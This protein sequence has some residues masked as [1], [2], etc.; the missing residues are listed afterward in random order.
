MKQLALIGKPNSGKSSLFNKLTGLNQKIGNYSGVT[1][2][3]KS[4][5]FNGTKI[6]DLPGLKSLWVDSLDEKISLQEILKYAEE[7]SPLL[8]VANGL[9]LADSLLLFS[10]IAD[11]QLPI[12]LVINFKDELKKSQLVLD[13]EKIKNH[14]GCEV[15]LMNSKTGEGLD[16]L[17][18][19]IRENKAKVPHTFRRSQFEKIDENGFQNIYLKSIID[20]Q[21]E[22]TNEQYNLLETD[23]SQRQV[24]V[25]KITNDVLKEDPTKVDILVGSKRAD[26]ILLHPIWGMLI[27]IAVMLVVF[28]SVF[29]LS[30]IPMDWIDQFFAWASE[31]SAKISIPWLSS[32]MSEGII[33][34]L[35]GVLIFIP[36]IAILFLLLGILENSGYLS[37]ISYI[38][39]NFLQKFGLS[40]KSVVPLMSSWACSIPAIMSTRMIED[41]RERMAVIMASPLMTCSARLPVYTILI[42]VMY[43]KENAGWIDAKGITLFA[44]YLL[45]VIATL[46]VAYIINK[47][48]NITSQS[49]W[50][51]ELPMYRMPNWK[52]VFYNAYSKTKSFVVSAGKIIFLISIV[53]WLLAS[54]S[55][56]T[57]SFIDQK[58]AEYQAT[59]QDHA[60]EVNRESIALEYSYAGYLGKVIEPVIKPL[61]Y[62][63]KIGIALITS[64]AAREVFVGTLSTIYSIGSEDESSIVERLRNETNLDTGE[65]RYN[66]ATSISLLLF[67]VFAM[68]CMSTLAIVRKE[69]GKWKYAAYQFA[70]MFV[71]AYGFAFL[72]YQLL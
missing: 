19:L 13:E 48:S 61:G 38:A 6:I 58:Y 70:F 66:M 2:E 7:G 9:Q 42:A 64:F 11:L 1:V 27:F 50:T 5:D 72:A 54:F 24:L 59:H 47:R 37:R 26:K 16:E 43:P 10:E 20:H 60:S 14:L 44:L 32:L 45:G 34:G 68:Q 23:F 46:V 22:F 55:P 29:T 49:A 4:G 33:P 35:G 51:L 3:K 21:N 28:Q 30:G 12:I 36:Q 41:S 63:W 52:N 18:K 65:K 15:V 39:D 8:F 67:Y 31:Q 53:L 69:T 57:E 17:E 62:D 56:K 71:L 25:S 40:G